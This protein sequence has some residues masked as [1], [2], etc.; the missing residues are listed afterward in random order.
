MSNARR[1]SAAR[2]VTRKTEEKR[3]AELDRGLRI[4]IDGEEYVVRLGDV[5]S[6]V[7]RELRAATGH[8]VHWLIGA[9][10][11]EPD[12][13]LIA[14]FVWLARRI[15]GEEVAFDDIEVSYR[16]LL[17]DGFDVDLADAEESA[18]PEA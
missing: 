5:T 14:E 4:V 7:A 13:D 11:V 3:D 17:D 18:G 6:R 15:R 2:K 12:V 10:S 1:P 16:Q 8:G 9:V